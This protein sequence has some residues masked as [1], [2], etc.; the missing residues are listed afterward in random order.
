[1]KPAEVTIRTRRNEP[2]TRRW[3][4]LAIWTMLVS[5]GN[6]AIVSAT[7]LLLAIYHAWD[8]E[9]MYLL[10]LSVLIPLA[11]ELTLGIANINAWNRLAISFRAEPGHYQSKLKPKENAAVLQKTAEVGA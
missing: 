5:L 2:V 7:L 1:M 9:G 6:G 10:A 11:I 8:D 3:S 4:R